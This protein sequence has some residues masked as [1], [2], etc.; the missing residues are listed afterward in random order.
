M[1]DL[2]KTVVVIHASN[3]NE[4][5]SDDYIEIEGVKYQKDP[6]NEG[7]A[8]KDDDGKPIPFKEKT[9]D[10]DGGG[11]KPDDKPDVAD[12]SIDELVKVNPEL[13][14]QMKGLKDLQDWKTKK[15]KEEEEAKKNKAKESG[16]FQELFDESEKEKETLKKQ[17][18]EKE[19]LLG[20]YKGSVEKILKGVMETISKEKHS[21][22]PDGFSPRQKLE[23]ITQNAKLLGAK[24]ATKV[25]D[26]IDESDD[27]SLTD[28]EK[29]ATELQELIKKGANRTEMENEHMTQLSRKLKEIR[30]KKQGQ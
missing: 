17:L 28:E 27:M 22:I 21:L 8:L 25:G 5:P 16:K 10:G 3:G 14:R 6:D 7:E 15:E 13:A 9:D 20:K 19:T 4:T 26:K 11:D 18:G 1:T 23:Y 24:V 2:N 30:A 12:M 29:L